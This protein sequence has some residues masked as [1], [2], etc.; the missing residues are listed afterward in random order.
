LYNCT[1]V[2]NR[3]GGDNFGYGGGT[4]YSTHEN[5]IIYFN[6]A[7][8]SPNGYDGIFDYS[9][10]APLPGSGT[11]NIAVDPL[12]V[13]LATTNLALS[14]GSPAIDAGNNAVVSGTID[15]NGQPRIVNNIVDV[16]AYEYQFNGGYWL[17]AADIING[18][19]NL[20]DSATDDGYPNLLKYVTGSSATVPDDLA[21]LTIA[22]TNGAPVTLFNR[23]PNA[24]DVTLIVESTTNLLDASWSGLATNVAGSWGASPWVTE[25]GAGS[26]RTVTLEPPD[27]NNRMY[28]LRVTRP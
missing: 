14:A 4:A 18:Q 9:C 25:T 26:P 6:T 2:G 13:S 19:T 24:I 10:T 7:N 17:W 3:A 1:V 28:R 27:A 8:N 16:G 21:S 15:V 23:N 20:T 12:F 5:S 11:G 22:L